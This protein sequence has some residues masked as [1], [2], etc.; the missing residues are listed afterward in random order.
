[1]F[2]V[3]RVFSCVRH[4]SSRAEKWTSVSPCP[5][6]LRLH[7]HPVQLAHARALGEHRVQLCDAALGGRHVI[8]VQRLGANVHQGDTSLASTRILVYRF[9]SW[10][11]TSY[12]DENK[13][14]DQHD[15]PVLAR[16]RVSRM[17][18]FTSTSMRTRQRSARQTECSRVMIIAAEHA[19]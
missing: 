17:W 7:S 15:R 10:A 4:G 19:G 9:T 2:R 5:L 18:A 3:C 6:P 16:V 1:M 11:F 8:Q 12:I 14:S 13:P